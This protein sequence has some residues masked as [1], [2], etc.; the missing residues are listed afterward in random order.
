MPRARHAWPLP[1]SFTEVTYARQNPA[2]QQFRIAA[3][4]VYAAHHRRPSDRAGRHC[5]LYHAAVLLRI[6]PHR[7]RVAHCVQCVHPHRWVVFVRT[8]V[9][10]TPPALAV[11][12]A[13]ALHGACHAAVQA[14][15]A[16]CL[17]RC[18]AVGG[19]PGLDPA[20]VVYLGLSAAVALRAAAEPRTARPAAR[21]APGAAGRAGRSDDPLPDAFRRERHR[22]R[23]CLDVFV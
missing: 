13:V 18:T 5:G 23:H 16:G 2:Q 8:A 15:R 1:R 11:A 12:V 9:Q 14:C 20:A 19:V 10:N 4:P 7:L 21:R 22:Q 17:L 6:L 3:H